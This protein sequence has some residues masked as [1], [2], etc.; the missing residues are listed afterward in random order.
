[1]ILPEDTF[2]SNWVL[3]YVELEKLNRG[4]QAS[5]DT[6]AEKLTL[7]RKLAN[8]Q[9]SPLDIACCDFLIAQ[10][11]L[12]RKKYQAAGEAFQGISNSMNNTLPSLAADAQWHAI[13]AFSEL[14]KMEPRNT[15]QAIRAI[16]QTIIQFPGSRLAKRASFEKIRINNARLT[17]EQAPAKS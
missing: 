4:D 2:V 6:A 3:G 14:A 13:V 1:M 12:K 9:T 10:T 15:F 11:D 16:D 7:A 5:L 17:T 8:K